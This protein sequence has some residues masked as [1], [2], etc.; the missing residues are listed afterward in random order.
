MNNWITLID[1]VAFSTDVQK[2][3]Q[4]KTETTIT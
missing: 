3:N 2:G 4:I 1:T